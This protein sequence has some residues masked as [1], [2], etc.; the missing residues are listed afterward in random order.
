MLAAAIKQGIPLSH[1]FN[2][3]PQMTFDQA[4]FATARRRPLRRH[5]SGRSSNSTDSRPSDLYTGTRESVNTFYAQLEQMTGLCEPYRAGQG[6]GHRA[7]EP[8]RRQSATARAGPVLHPRRR[9]TSAR[10]RWPRPTR[11]SPAAACTA[12]PARSPRSWTPSATRVK[13]YPS[14]CTQVIP[15]SDRRRRQRRAARACRSPAASAP[16]TASQLDQPSAGKTGTT[17]D[18][19]S[20]WF[21][22]YTPELATAAMIAGANSVGHADHAGRPD[23]RRRLHLDRVRLRLRRPD[24]G[25]RDAGHRRSGCR[26]P[27]S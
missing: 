4:D 17:Q 20:V 13:D 8:D 21:V 18:G 7:H 10:S 9:R 22:G 6:D 1:A 11:P 2:A 12:T 27:T 25:R 23:R 15:Q 26:T 5:A 19:K 16:S 24:V 3:P 14:Q